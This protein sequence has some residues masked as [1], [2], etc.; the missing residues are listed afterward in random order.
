MQKSSHSGFTLIEM[1]VVVGIIAVLIGAS[2]GAYTAFV[3]Q[4]QRQRAVE[5]VYQVKTALSQIVQQDDAWPPLLLQANKGDHLLGQKAGAS[6]AKRKVMQLTARITRNADGGNDY[7]L[8]GHD[9]FGIVTPWAMDVIKHMGTAANLSSKV[10]T[11]G[12]I[13]DH[14]LR[15]AIDDDRDGFTEINHPELGGKSIKVR[16]M[17]C[18]WCL[19]RDGKANTSDDVRSWTKAM[20]VTE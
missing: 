11:G 6:L 12:T 7:I 13:K 8:T 2:M 18:V 16:A 9:R 4:A 17:A 1:L 20:E 15:F 5:Q 10:A 3:R 14:I 19:G